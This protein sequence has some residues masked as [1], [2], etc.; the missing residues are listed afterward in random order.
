VGLIPGC[1]VGDELEGGGSPDREGALCAEEGDGA[2]PVLRRRL[3]PPEAA[4]QA[5]DCGALCCPVHRP[6]VKVVGGVGGGQNLARCSCLA[7]GG[8]D[9]L[10]ESIDLLPERAAVGIVGTD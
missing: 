1:S 9:G 10:K 4:E 3:L 8:R 7:P 6:G 5:V 2:A